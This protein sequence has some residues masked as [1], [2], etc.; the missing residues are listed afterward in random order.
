[1]SLAIDKP[2]QTIDLSM[3][4]E[5]TRRCCSFALQEKYYGR[6][7]ILAD[8]ELVEQNSGKK[9]VTFC[10]TVKWAL[11]Q[12]IRATSTLRQR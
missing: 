2:Y 7:V 11:G 6:E 4:L 9:K 5:I 8:R 12:V 3:A 10:H 1:M